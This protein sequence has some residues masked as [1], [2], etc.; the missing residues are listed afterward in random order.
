MQPCNIAQA[1]Y[2]AIVT[3]TSTPASILMIICFTTSVGALR[4]S[5]PSAREPHNIR[6][7]KPR[8]PTHSIN[9]L[10]ILISYVSHVLLPSPHGVLRVVIF[11]LLVGRRMGPLTRRSLDF[12]RSISSWQTFSSDCTLREVREMRILWIFWLGRECQRWFC[13]SRRI[14]VLGF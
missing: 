8:E 10:W 9:R 13:V 12:A 5:H 6:P 4:L 3:S 1:S 14:G 7:P 2:A 11:R